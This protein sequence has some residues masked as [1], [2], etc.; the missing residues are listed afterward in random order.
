MLLCVG[1]DTIRRAEFERYLHRSPA[2]SVEEFL[3]TFI[4]FRTKVAHA[5][6]LGLDTLASYRM[7]LRHY[8]DA[9]NPCVSVRPLRESEEWVKVRHITRRL[10]QDAGKTE[11][12]K[13]LAELD[14]LRNAEAFA[15]ERAEVLEIPR[16]LL[17]NEWQEQIDKLAV[18]EVSRPFFSPLGVHVLRWEERKTVYRP[19]FDEAENTTTLDEREL[20]DAL[21]VAALSVRRQEE[22]TYTE[23]DLEA[24]FRRHRADYAT[25]VP[26]YRGAVVHSRSK[27]AAKA[28]KKYLKQYPPELWQEACARMPETLAEN[29][30][31]EAGLFH[32]GTNAYIDKLVFKC[33]D[34]EP[35]ADYP[36]TSV[37]GRKLKKGSV[38]LNDVRA[39]VEHD[40]RKTRTEAEMEA[41]KRKYRVEIDEEV[42]KT[43]NSLGNK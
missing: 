29:C 33:G 3:P 39:D 4:D 20:G 37:L 21:L 11:Q 10:H 26:S 2:A 18:N 43:V 34:F 38:G 23:Q 42:L 6:A 14:S 31:V 36:H 28:V 7:Q 17:L 9:V 12:R 30:R 1:C 41:L 5:K 15:E 22:P 27:Q 35:L 16:R 13:A 25:D 19:S 32:I 24:Y 8:L 40:Y